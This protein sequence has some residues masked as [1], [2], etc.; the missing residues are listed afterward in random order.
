MNLSS[1]AIYPPKASL[2]TSADLQRLVAVATY[3]DGTTRDITNKVTFEPK[4]TSLVTVA[5]NMI[6]PR[7][8]GET[9]ISV[10]FHNN[11]AT[12]P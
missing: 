7:A 6:R 3:S 1:I 10:N 11:S 9:S 2:T 12:V 5:G 8:D 4:N